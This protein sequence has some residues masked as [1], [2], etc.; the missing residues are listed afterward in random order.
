MIYD[1]P[2][3]KGSQNPLPFAVLATVIA[4]VIG[5]QIIIFDGDRRSS[6]TT[7]EVIRLQEI[8]PALPEQCAEAR[9]RC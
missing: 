1:L 7:D 8:I 9:P 5:I 3:A 2:E 6:A 4:L